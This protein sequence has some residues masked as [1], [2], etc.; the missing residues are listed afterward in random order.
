MPSQSVADDGF[1]RAESKSF[2]HRSVRHEGYS[3]TLSADRRGPDG[4]LG[5]RQGHV[6]GQKLRVHPDELGIGSGDLPTGLEHLAHACRPWLVTNIVDARLA[7][8]DAVAC[9]LRQITHVDE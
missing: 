9:E 8:L 2:R 7:L 4:Q 3:A 1:Q 6:L 5:A